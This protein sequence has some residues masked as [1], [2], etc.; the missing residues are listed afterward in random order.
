MWRTL[1]HL[2]IPHRGAVCLGALT[3]ACHFYPLGSAIRNVCFRAVFR[4][5]RLRWLGFER[6]RSLICDRRQ[7]PVKG[8]WRTGSPP[9]RR[10][11][12]RWI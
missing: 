9:D 2:R 5:D 8:A 10:P 4:A 3:A 12:G 6:E 7:E 11:V 1:H